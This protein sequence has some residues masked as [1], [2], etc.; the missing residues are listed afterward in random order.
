MIRS[1]GNLERPVL[2]WGILFQ[3]DNRLE[4]RTRHLQWNGE[5]PFLFMT[6]REARAFIEKRWGYIR[7]RPDLKAEP[8]GWKMPKAVKVAV[9]LKMLE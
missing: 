1:L 3:S 5:A 4:G 7:T 6:R 2:R 8:H 9:I